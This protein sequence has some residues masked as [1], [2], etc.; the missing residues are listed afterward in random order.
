MAERVRETVSHNYCP[1]EVSVREAAVGEVT[2]ES[3]AQ[4]GPAADVVDVDALP[5]ADVWQLDCE[6]TEASILKRAALPDRLVVE[7][8]PERCDESRVVE[9]LPVHGARDKSVDAPQWIA[10]VDQRVT[11]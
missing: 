6:G 5:D 1:A 8:H 11:G 2:A 9:H 4:Y 3:V 7:V 10:T